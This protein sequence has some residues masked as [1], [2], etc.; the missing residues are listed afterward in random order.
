M[1]MRNGQTT[2]ASAGTAVPLLGVTYDTGTVIGTVGDNHLTGDDVTTPAL[3]FS[4]ITGIGTDGPTIGRHFYILT[5]GGNRY[6]IAAVLSATLL[7]LKSAVVTEANI[8]TGVTF[9]I[10]ELPDT[11]E[12]L[13]QSEQTTA[14]EVIYLGNRG[15]VS[16]LLGF[17]IQPTVT[18]RLCGFNLSGNDLWIDAS[19]DNLTLTW[20][21]KT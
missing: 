8:A 20:A 14:T 5:A 11:E 2:V 7:K 13:L 18:V 9:R 21:L 12:V 19:G 6:E 16:A 3:D 10:Y 4:T 15:A 1:G 17:A